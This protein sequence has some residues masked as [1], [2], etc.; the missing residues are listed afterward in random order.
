MNQAFEM[1]S[2]DH[3]TLIISLWEENTTIVLSFRNER[4]E[5]YGD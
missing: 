2:F 3:L 4:T 1:V 5:A